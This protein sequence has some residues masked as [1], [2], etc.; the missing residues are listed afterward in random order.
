MF[1]PLTWLIYAFYPLT[2]PVIV[3]LLSFDFATLWFFLFFENALLCYFVN[4]YYPLTFAILW[5]GYL[6]TLLFYVFVIL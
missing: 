5:F 6:L 2:V 1:D 3:V 4:Y